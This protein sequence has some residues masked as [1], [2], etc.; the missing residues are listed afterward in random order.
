MAI[1][2]FGAGVQAVK[3]AMLKRALDE[4]ALRHRMQS[5]D[6]E[7]A[8]R[9][10]GLDQGQQ[11]FDARL[12]MDRDKLTEDTR[13]YDEAAPEREARTGMIR[14]QTRDLEQRPL[15]AEQAR[16]A[17]E[18]RDKTQHQYRLGEIGAQ[19]AGR[20]PRDV[21]KLWIIR[22]G[23]PAY[24][25]ED[26]VMPGDLPNNTREQGRPSLGAEKTALGFFNRML[27][28]ERD[29]RAVEKETGNWDAA[30]SGGIP[31]LPEFAENALKSGA[32]QKYTQAQR[33]Y[34]EARLRKE[35][36]AAINK[37]EYENDRRM[38]FRNVGDKDDTLA[39]KRAQRLTTLRGL[40]TQAGRALQEHYGD[41]A[42]LDA[43]L[44]EFE[45]QASPQ[46]IRQRNARTGQVRVSTDGG[47]TWQIQ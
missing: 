37:D 24:V 44:K 43:L 32:G 16:Q 30:L 47:K 31:L 39:Q 40:G 3:V 14:T 4:E 10:R 15:Y 45:E 19:V 2:D 13:R 38:S 28:A 26:Q 11:Q 33:A 41:D 21:K 29:A 27:Q 17:Q 20:A 9:G 42:N 46:V 22:N 1:A 35:S 7:L 25:T 12:G 18:Q 6:Q 23:K 5:V 8:L 34:T 36:G